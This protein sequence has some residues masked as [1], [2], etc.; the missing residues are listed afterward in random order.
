MNTHIFPM[1]VPYKAIMPDYSLPFPTRELAQKELTYD[2]C[3]GKIPE[4][5]RARIVDNAWQKGANA[6][7]D[8]WKKH[9]GERDF[10]IISSRSGLVCTRVNADYVIN[11]RRYFSDYVSGQ[12][13]ITLYTQ[14]IALWAKQ[15][16]LSQPQAENLILSHEYYHFLEWTALGLTSQDYLV[17]MLQIGSFKI[18]KTGIRA[19]SEIGAHAFARTYYELIG[20]EE[21]NHADKVKI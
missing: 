14:S 21:A 1:C 3:Y 17:P 15:N 18:G 19:L 12:N 2:F 11:N 4:K 20:Q 13:K 16:A 9:K 8:T 7:L 10:F 5:D 6:A